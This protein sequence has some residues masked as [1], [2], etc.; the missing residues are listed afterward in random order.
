MFEPDAMIPESF[1]EEVTFGPGFEA[2]GAGAK[3]LKGWELV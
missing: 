1:L 2:E 3:V